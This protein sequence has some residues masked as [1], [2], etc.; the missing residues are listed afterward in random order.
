[1]DLTELINLCKQINIDYKIGGKTASINSF[2]VGNRANIIVFPDNIKKL[3]KILDLVLVN[4]Y[5]YVVIGNGTN[6]YFCDDYDGVVIVTKQINSIAVENNC[7]LA[8]CGASITACASVALN[9]ALEGFEFSY[10]IPGTVGGAVYINA[11]AFGSSVSNIVFESLVYDLKTRSIK[12][13]SKQE[14]QFKTKES[15]FSKEKSY[16][17]LS[18]KFLLENGN[19]QSIKEKMEK[20]LNRRKETQPLDLPSAGSVFVKPKDAYASQLIDEAGL[21]GYRIGGAEISKKHAG[22]IVNVASATASDINSLIK[23]VKAIIKSKYNIELK[24]EIIYIE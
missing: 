18:T 2:M 23:H 16:I 7:I 11:S 20:Y 22:F 5:K 4:K 17:V 1:M 8:D 14:H 3:T 10:G 6:V 15:I 19:I 12:T 13:I 24:E 9:N 21:K